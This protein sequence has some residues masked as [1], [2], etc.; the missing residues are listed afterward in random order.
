MSAKGSSSTVVTHRELVLLLLKIIKVM[1]HLTAY[2]FP[3]SL[4]G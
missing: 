3:F 4:T 1:V 2:L